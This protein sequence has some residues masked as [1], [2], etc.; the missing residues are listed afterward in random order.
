MDK[1]ESTGET[2]DDEDVSLDS[3]E[4]ARYLGDSGDNIAELSLSVEDNSTNN[5]S[6][7][8]PSAATQ[9]PL[10]EVTTKQ[11]HL[12][13]KDPRKGIAIGKSRWRVRW[14]MVDKGSVHLF[15]NFEKTEPYHT[16]YMKESEIVD[17]NDDL[18][19][20]RDFVFGIR[21]LGGNTANLEPKWFAASSQ[22]DADGW[23]TALSHAISQEP[24][25][26][27]VRPPVPRSQRT[28][29]TLFRGISF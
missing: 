28:D 5:N 14:I 2:S 17:S 16:I 11:G 1:H 21:S 6:N 24:S 10:I 8:T 4:E 29:G 9:P 20:E 18:G 23:R 13:V 15:S 26:P 3:E 27:P 25:A 22:S 7:A 19:R 12:E